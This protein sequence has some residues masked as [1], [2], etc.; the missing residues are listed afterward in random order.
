MPHSTVTCKHQLAF[1][2]QYKIQTFL[3]HKQK[4]N[5][6]DLA[7]TS[8]HISHFLYPGIYGSLNQAQNFCTHCKEVCIC[9]AAM[10]PM[11]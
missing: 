9:L 6:N 2:F 8:M 5:L 1:S 11:A 4:K 3:Y 7:V 10:I